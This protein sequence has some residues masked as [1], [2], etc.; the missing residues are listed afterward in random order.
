MVEHK[1]CEI[2]I[3]N[4]Q[5]ILLMN[6]TAVRAIITIRRDCSNSAQNYCKTTDIWKYPSKRSRSVLS[7]WTLGRRRKHWHK[8]TNNGHPLTLEVGT[9]VLL[10][11]CISFGN[12]RIVG[13]LRLT[14]SIVHFEAV[15]RLEKCLLLGR[16]GTLKLGISVDGITIELYTR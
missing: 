1:S 9:G 14:A 12:W 2:Q 11:T 16:D 6:R 8:Y 15:R 3:Q 13:S 7:F 4:L 10:F 5:L